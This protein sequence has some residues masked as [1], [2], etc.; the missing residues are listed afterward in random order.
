MHWEYTA[1][2][3]VISGWS[4]RGD[5]IS[6]FMSHLNGLGADGWEL[7]TETVIHTAGY[8]GTQTPMLIF[9]RPSAE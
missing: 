7:V 2:D 3:T 5:Q 1:V 8:S 9:K 6:N 4:D